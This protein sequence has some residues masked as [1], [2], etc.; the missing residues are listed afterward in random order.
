MSLIGTLNDVRLADVLRLF[1]ST[2]KTGLLTATAPGREAL[3]RLERGVVVNAVSGR[4]QGDDAVIDLFGWGDGQLTFVPEEKAVDRNVT[5]TVELLVEE[6]LRDGPTF[7][8][9]QEVMS[10]DR[11]VFQMAA[12][13]P[14]D[15]I[16]T[17]GPK[18]W[19]VLRVLDGLRDVREVVEASG[20]SRTEV[21]RVLFALTEAGFLERLELAR[22]L[23]AQALGRLG[24]AAAEVDGRLLAEWRR[25]ARFADGVA[26][27]EVGV[28]RSRLAV[29]DVAFRPGLGR[30]VNLP[31]ATIAELAVREG[32]D[33]IVKPS[34]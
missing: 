10:S 6:G 19:G 22:T 9:M 15:A 8:R 7:H 29:V 32:D 5:K 34:I 21:A 12:Q 26:R 13:P 25:A 30:T 23:K 4:L 27:I 17:L 1:G 11:L 14:E 33:V 18:E 16:C 31:R 3:V 28:G 2:R 24:G 20:Q